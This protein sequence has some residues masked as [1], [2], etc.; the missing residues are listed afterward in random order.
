M[1]QRYVHRGTSGAT[2]VFTSSDAGM[3]RMLCADYMVNEMRSRA[4]TAE[5]VAQAISPEGSGEYKESFAVSFGIGVSSKG[6]KRAFGRL[7]NLAPHALYVEWGNTNIQPYRVLRR[8]AGQVEFKDK[9][10]RKGA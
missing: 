3:T 2:A 6:T 9:Y 1:S 4:E 7:A 10:T 5:G 8:A